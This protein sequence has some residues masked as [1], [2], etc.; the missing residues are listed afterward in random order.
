MQQTEQP[1]T[2]S[3]PASEIIDIPW[4]VLDLHTALVVDQQQMVVK[5]HK[6]VQLAEEM[7]SRLGAL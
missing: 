1:P 2:Q 5:P 3:H 4:I 7:E 6:S